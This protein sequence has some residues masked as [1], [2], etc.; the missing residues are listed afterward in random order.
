MYHQLP[1][2]EGILRKILQSYTLRY[3]KEVIEQRRTLFCAELDQCSNNLTLL[4]DRLIENQ[5][6]NALFAR[7]F[8]SIRRR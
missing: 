1:D 8:D 5:A 4:Y 6:V 7:G 3:L 2:I